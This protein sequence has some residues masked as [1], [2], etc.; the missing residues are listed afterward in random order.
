MNNISIEDLIEVIKSYNKEEVDIVRRTYEFAKELHKGQKRQ[1][2]DDYIT[3]PLN[4]A[5]IL[6]EMHADRDTVCAGLLHDTLED[7]HVT[8]EEIRE[9]FNPTI[10]DLVDGVT[11]L[12]KM[13]FSSKEEQN[14]ANTRKIITGITE[15]VRIIIIKLADRLHNMR[16]LQ[17]KSEFKQKENALE[18]M[19]IFVPLAYYIGAYRIKSELEDLSLRYLKPDM[20]K[21]IEEKK[22]TIEESCNEILEEMLYKIKKILNDRNIPN[23]IKVRTKNIYGIYKRREEGHNLDD[24]HDLLALKIM[25]DEIDSCYLTLGMIH[26]I[27]HPINDKFKDYICNPKTNMYRSL[28]TTVFGP[29]DKLVQ[30]QIRTFDMDKVASFGLT[31]YFDIKKG[32]ARNIMQEELKNKYQFFRS[33]VEI[34][35]VFG[36]NRDFVNRVKE[37]LFSDNIYVYTYEGK[38][39][40]LPKGA[41]PIDLAYEIDTNLGNM[42]DSAIVKD[43]EVEPDYI[44][45]NKDRV[46]IITNNLSLGPKEE[47]ESIVKTTKAKRKIREFNGG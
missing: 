1:S 47:W 9:L 5:Y 4:V 25:V 14:L 6:A 42:I 45:K 35:K 29:N 16:T 27:Y 24:I 39:Y 44:L 43:I 26:S 11:K 33:L 20:Y 22:L 34:N 17:F 19:D 37:E 7:T 10:A 8:K 30:T 32:E 2:G 3:H 38:I 15:D 46:R 21:W 36:D 12:A 28:H 31:A 13:N 41:T 40:Q 18:T 23:E